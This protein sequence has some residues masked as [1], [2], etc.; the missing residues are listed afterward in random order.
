VPK[1]VR[2]GAPFG[3]D[4]LIPGLED[5][6]VVSMVWP[7]IATQ[8]YFLDGA[9]SEEEVQVLVQCIMSLQAQSLRWKFTIDSSLEGLA[10]R[11]TYEFAKVYSGT[12]ETWIHYFRWQFRSM[13]FLLSRTWVLSELRDYNLLGNVEELSANQF[14]SLVLVLRKVKRTASGNLYELLWYTIYKPPVRA[15][16]LA[17]LTPLLGKPRAYSGFQHPL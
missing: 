13:A 10:V 2:Q 4:T 5:D 11:T 7:K 14:Q 1:H 8:L 9:T 17:F 12:E 6:I 15:C 16:S 3:T